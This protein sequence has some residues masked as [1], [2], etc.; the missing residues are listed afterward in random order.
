MIKQ[1]VDYV[2]F[3]GEKR[4]IDLYFNFTE[5][6]LVTWETEESHFDHENQK[7]TG[8]FSE[9]MSRIGK[10]TSG[11]EIMQ[12][13]QE[14][15][16][17][18]YGE[19]SA[20]GEHFEKSPEIFDRFRKTA[21]YDAFF[22]SMVTDAKKM[23]IFVN[24]LMPESRREAVS[25]PSDAPDPNWRP[26]APKNADEPKPVQATPSVDPEYQAYLEEKRKREQTNTLE[27]Q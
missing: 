10:S 19:K 20:D 13:F 14:I 11:K 27:A 5:A 22:M 9:R 24:G 26:Q 8:G 12:A 2:N 1:H 23:E 3:N 21:A 16:E 25:R 4:S 15:L 18:S 7:V 17:K 6:E